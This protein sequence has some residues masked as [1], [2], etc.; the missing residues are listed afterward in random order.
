MA[1]IARRHGRTRWQACD[2]RKKLR[3]GQLVV[4]ESVA[5]LPM[6]AELVVEAP[7]AAMPA[8]TELATGVEIV[9]GDVVIRLGADADEALLTRSIRAVRAA[10]MLGQGGAVKVYVATRPVDLR[11]GIDGLALAVQEMVGLDPFCGAVFVFRAKRADRIKLLVWGQTG[12][13]LVHKCLE[14]AAFVWSPIRL[15][16]LF[17]GRGAGP[18]PANKKSSRREIV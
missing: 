6:L 5:A 18:S 15:P 8:E 4:P 17:A 1:D 7:A 9:V 14:G 3:T 10:V 13:V 12:M 2:W 11:K 16:P